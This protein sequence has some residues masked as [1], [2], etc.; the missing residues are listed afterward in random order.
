MGEPVAEDKMRGN[1]GQTVHP[2]QPRDERNTRPK[3]RRGAPRT[4]KARRTKITETGDVCDAFAVPEQ[5]PICL[6]APDPLTPCKVTCAH[7]GYE[8]YTSKDHW[9]DIYVAAKSNKQG[10]WCR[11]CYHL[12]WV[13]L[14]APPQSQDWILQEIAAILKTLDGFHR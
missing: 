14:I 3:N 8:W 10:P 5:P 2:L 1:E 7:C 6:S 13:E 12:K 4:G 9:R 11:L